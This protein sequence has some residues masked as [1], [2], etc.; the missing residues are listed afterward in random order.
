MMSAYYS[1]F[2]DCTASFRFY[3]RTGA[4]N[5]TDEF[6]VRLNEQLD[7][8]CKLQFT[9]DELDYIFKLSF[10]KNKPG[11]RDVL[12]HFF[13]DRRAIYV[14]NDGGR[15]QIWT[16]ETNITIASMFEIYVLAIVNELHCQNT[17]F[18]HN[19]EIEDILTDYKNAR[20]PFAEFGTRRR[21]SREFQE[22]VVGNLTKELS[23][24]IFIGTSNVYLAKKY[25]I[26]P[27]GTFAHEYLCLG[28][29]LRGVPLLQ[30]QTYML[31][32]WLRH[33]NGDLSIALTDNLG[34]GKFL[35]D[36]SQ[37]FAR[38]FEGLRHDSG[39]PIKWARLMVDMYRSYYINPR[40]KTL[41]F[42]DSINKERADSIW[43][44][45]NHETNV[46]FGIGTSLTNPRN[47]TNIVFKM[48]T[49]NR[50]PVAKLSDDP[51]KAT[52]EDP[53]Y[54]EF[55]KRFVGAKS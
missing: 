55:L 19:K 50:K 40:T 2:W 43:E 36:F 38:M 26:R 13:L 51:H 30:S 16:K 1:G 7:H 18:D 34:V 4:I 9:E 53:A 44:A 22:M 5:A 20:F 23:S 54:I 10:F 12:K 29:N 41:F 45:I 11:F 46:V 39:C 37:D 8:L 31:D 6:M 27:I 17:P 25:N 14:S 48:A 49:A 21:A 15:L 47:P 32:F 28:Q 3:D 24:D 33:F 52:C 42:S 35:K